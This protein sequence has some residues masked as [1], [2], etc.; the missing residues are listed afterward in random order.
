MKT[1]FNPANKDP[2]A[3][4]KRASKRRPRLIGLDI[5]LGD[6]TCLLYRTSRQTLDPKDSVLWHEGHKEFIEELQVGF[7]TYQPRMRPLIYIY[8]YMYVTV[9]LYGYII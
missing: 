4:P 9:C 5:L 6:G 3:D 7:R 8:I 1:V 2:K